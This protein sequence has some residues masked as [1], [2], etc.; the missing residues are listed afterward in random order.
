MF[1]VRIVPEEILPSSSVPRN[2]SESDN[3]SMMSGV[4]STDAKVEA[5]E[6]VDAIPHSHMEENQLKDGIP[7][8]RLYQQVG[9]AS[10]GSAARRLIEQ[11]GAY[12]NGQ[13]IES[14]DYLLTE[15]DIVDF[16]ILLRAGKKRYHKLKIIKNKS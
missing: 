13:R 16:E 9:L 10:S 1:G 2:G 6:E 8:F 14:Y 5:Q 11:G 3:I 7:A 12:V 4:S 15:N